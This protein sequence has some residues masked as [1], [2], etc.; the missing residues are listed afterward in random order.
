M[1]KKQ[2]PKIISKKH[3][4][5]QE[6]EARQTRI[7]TWSAIGIVILVILGIAYGILN[8]TVF[9]RFRPAVTVNGE[10]LSMQDFQVRVRATRQS[11][12]SQYMQY[13]QFG[14]MLGVDP[15]S[16]PSMSQALDQIT[17][18]LNSPSTLGSQIIDDMVNSLLVRQ[19]AKKNGITVTSAEV[20][21]AIQDALGYYPNGT[22]TPTLTPTT[23]IEPTLNATQLA[24]VTPTITPTTAPTST[25]R[26]T[27][28]PNLTATKTA[29]PSITPTATPYTLQGFEK[30]F[31]DVRKNYA[32]S[33]M[34]LQQFRTIY[35]ED[36]LY[37]D[38]VKAKV[39]ADVKHEQE[40][41]WARHIL[42]ADENTANSVYTQ[43]KAGA[44]FAT[45]A[46]KYSIDT[47]TKDKGGDLGWFGKG[48][49]VP[50]FEAAVW[51]MKIGDINKPF[52]ST[53]GYHIVQ[54][55]GHEVRPLTET[56]YNDA[57][58]AAYDT[59][60]QNERAN[61]KVVINDNWTKYVPTTPTLEQA[62]ANQN[63]TITAY[64]KTYSSGQPTPTVKK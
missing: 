44:D 8:D 64:I 36:A 51:P 55:L 53:Y 15:S 7:I 32:P 41:V 27:W 9:L 59:W 3:L 50:D 22:P 37:T 63:A 24:L 57:V 4:A 18:Q 42:V 16:D 2:A 13:M 14:Q 61:S 45:L 62:Q 38:K 54:V 5:R 21:K 60:L 1:A 28:T 46:A 56:E 31:N 52:K 34:S 30:Q 10:T 47:N 48:K 35:Y 39:T 11:L 29:I 23:V 49:M 19:Y 40:M 43:L 6:R 12:I 58:T 26:P 25:T 33:G 20:D 17:S